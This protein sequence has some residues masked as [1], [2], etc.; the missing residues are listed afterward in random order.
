MTV[1]ILQSYLSELGEAFLAGDFER[2]SALVALP[3][4]VRTR[5]A[6]LWVEDPM[7]LEEG[8]DCQFAEACALGVERIERRAI[9]VTSM[10]NRCI[11]GRCASH[12][13]CGRA[14]VVLSY[15]ADITLEM[16]QPCWKMSAFGLQSE[17]TRWPLMVHKLARE[18][19]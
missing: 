8:F 14:E 13:L 6:N 19:C 4:E 7:S 2:Y 9:T 12:W 16:Y 3:L 10:S 5:C 11:F 17:D 15:T 18:T 1:R